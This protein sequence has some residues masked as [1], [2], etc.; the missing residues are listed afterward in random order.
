MRKPCHA[1]SVARI[2]AP[3]IAKVKGLGHNFCMSRDFNV[4]M[5]RADDLGR[6]VED[7]ELLAGEDGSYTREGRTWV[8]N[9]S[10]DSCLAED[11]PDEVFPL[12]PGAGFLASITLEPR[13]A[14]GRAQALARKLARA[15]A[16]AGEG[17]IE[18]GETG[19]ITLATSA[20]GR[21][22]VQDAVART[23]A[24][25]GLIRR[26]FGQRQGDVADPARIGELDL[27]WWMDH[28]RLT[29]RE[30]M[31]D[32][33]S[34]LRRH[35]PEALP[36]RYGPFEPPRFKFAETGD[37]HFLEFLAGE[38]FAVVYPRR[39]CTKA[40]YPAGEDQA[41][42]VRMGQKRE[43]KAVKL[44][45][46]FEARVLDNPDWRLRLTTAFEAISEL[47]LP[48]YGEVRL[49]GGR[50]DGRAALCH[51][52][53]TEDHPVWGPWW[54]GVPKRPAAARVIG[55][56]YLAHWSPEGACL[57]SGLVLLTSADWRVPDDAV[58][59]VPD[60]IAQQSH[61]EDDA[62]RGAVSLHTKGDT[63]PKV[64]PFPDDT[65]QPRT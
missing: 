43:F 53:K 33:L 15:L 27:S 3:Y 28:D 8:L 37:D 40:S 38:T 46:G 20:R 45:L 24:K 52:A 5:R 63:Y 22:E 59:Q 61:V 44:S 30:G 23:E 17:C 13:A 34:L 48:F 35:L 51:D 60:P 14:P 19:K 41:G 32:C 50:L 55:P 9:V 36:R 64:F 57:P 6:V 65:A 54:A 16:E 10:I 25:P 58:N 26:I 49:L 2:D 1:P 18:D 56:R 62:Q 31:R 42:W 39:P 21:A 11:L 47:V 4:W 7:L 29:T 12:I